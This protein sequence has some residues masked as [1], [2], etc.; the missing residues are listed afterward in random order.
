MTDFPSHLVRVK[1]LIKR[2]RWKYKDNL[3][4]NNDLTKIVWWSIPIVYWRESDNQYADWA[5][6]RR[7]EKKKRI[8]KVLSAMFESYD[9]MYFLT[10]TFADKAFENTTDRT[11]HR[12]ASSFLNAISAD[13]IANVDYG[14]QN[15]REH[16]HAIVK[17]K[18]GVNKDIFKSWEYG[19]TNYKKI[20]T[21][22]MSS[23]KEAKNK[24]YLSSYISK[25]TNHSGKLSTGKTFRKRLDK[26]V[27]PDGQVAE[28]RQLDP[29]KEL[30][31]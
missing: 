27:L 18:N 13:Y 2:L 7:H 11:R 24:R 9:V 17:L 22:K 31:F 19:F 6:E 30:P 23:D 15:H 12:Y 29:E 16:Y 26:V 8:N 4:L 25:L 5:I 1:Y 28:L 21:L 20:D 3:K 14:E 10:L